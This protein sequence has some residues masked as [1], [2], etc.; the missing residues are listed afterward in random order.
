MAR[1]KLDRQVLAKLLGNNH[2]AIVAFEAMLGEVATALPDTIDEVSNT[3]A[4]AIA[5]A[6]EA[7]SALADVAGALEMLLAAPAREDAPDPDDT[8]PRLQVGTLAAQDSDAVDITGGRIGLDAGAVG[9]PSIYLGGEDATGLYR[10]AANSWGMSIAGVKLF[11]LSGLAAA[12]E[13]NVST[14]KQLVS[15][16]AAGTAPLVVTSTTNVPNLNASTLSGATFAAPGAIGLTTP[17]AAAF[18]SVGVGNNEPTEPLDVNGNIRAYGGT[19]KTFGNAGAAKVEFFQNS[20]NWSI[21][22]TAGYMQFNDI[23][24]GAVRWKCVGG[25]HLFNAP[26]DDGVTSFQCAGNSK[27]AGTVTASGQ[28]VS[29]V[30]SGAPPFVVDSTNE[31]LNLRAA[32]ASKLA[33]PTIFPANATDLATAITLVNALRAAA[34]DKGL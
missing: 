31:V 4:S 2:E 18:S 28:I 9:A 29:T 14:T 13:Q 25:R 12:F 22:V 16:V 23:S 17:S 5:T 27:F 3:A 15:T 33:N 24:G 10:A 34:V 11:T 7:L 6:R 30:A 20:G 19:F 26:A 32:A 8:A 21:D 1:L